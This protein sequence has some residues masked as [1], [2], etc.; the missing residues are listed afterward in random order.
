MRI[1]CEAPEGRALA[2]FAG[3]TLELH[4]D[5]R[6]W[7]KTMRFGSGYLG[8]NDPRLHVGLGDSDGEISLR[9]RGRSLLVEPGAEYELR[10]EDD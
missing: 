3:E 2:S 1:A 8:G 6:S 7:H 10:L 4:A 9:W 5:D